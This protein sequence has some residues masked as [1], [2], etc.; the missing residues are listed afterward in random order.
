MLLAKIFIFFVFKKDGNFWL[1][2][3]YYGL[4]IITIKNHYF[5]LLIIKILDYLYKVAVFIKIN[6]KN[7]YY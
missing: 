4:N 3:N 1:Y 6:L 2:V 7:V 5:L